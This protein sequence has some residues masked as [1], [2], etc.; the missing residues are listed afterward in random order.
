MV[1]IL[2]TTWRFCTG[3]TSSQNYSLTNSDYSL[4]GENYSWS[5]LV[6]HN[7]RQT[8]IVRCPKECPK[9]ILGKTN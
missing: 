4:S 6:G 5:N 2:Y 8:R 7:K 3:N 1:I 9:G